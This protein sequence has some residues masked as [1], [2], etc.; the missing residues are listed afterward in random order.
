M[1]STSTILNVRDEHMKLALFYLIGVSKYAT[2]YSMSVMDGNFRVMQTPSSTA[3]VCKS[4]SK[5]DLYE[6]SISAMMGGKYEDRMSFME[7]VYNTLSHHGLS[8]IFE[9]HLDYFQDVVGPKLGNAH[10]RVRVIALSHFF[11]TFIYHEKSQDVMAASSPVFLNSDP[12]A[13]FPKLTSAR[14]IDIGGISVHH[15]H[16]KLDKVAF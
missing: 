13:D 14:V 3:Y 8:Y 4:S 2:T 11:C 6:V 12:L 9:E 10:I 15:G 5:E 7:R 16:K 1:V